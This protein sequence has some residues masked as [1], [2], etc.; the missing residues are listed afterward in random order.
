MITTNIIKYK[1]SSCNKLRQCFYKIMELEE[2]VKYLE[3]FIEHAQIVPRFKTGDIVY[4][5][6]EKI[7]CVVKE[8]QRH[9]G[10]G[11]SYWLLKIS[12]EG[13]RNCVAGENEMT[14]KNK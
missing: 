2:Q 8:F 13:C 6:D 11:G 14:L 5:T 4:W 9:N 1:M 10:I 12:E 3:N 7:E